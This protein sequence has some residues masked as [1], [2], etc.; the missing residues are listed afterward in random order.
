MIA[1]LN[2]IQ[3]F[4]KSSFGHE[5]GAAIYVCPNASRVLL[6][7]GLNPNRARMVVCRSVRMPA[8]SRLGLLSINVPGPGNLRVFFRVADKNEIIG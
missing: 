8:A 3:I 5:I 7:W 1:S 4:E 2:H 6:P